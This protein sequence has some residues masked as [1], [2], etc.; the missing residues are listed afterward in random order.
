MQRSRT[1]RL[2]P[3]ALLDTSGCPAAPRAGGRRF[4]VAAPHTGDRSLVE[5]PTKIRR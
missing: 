5:L 1:P 2:V 3:G 4:T